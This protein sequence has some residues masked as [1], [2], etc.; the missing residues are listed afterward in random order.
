MYIPITISYYMYLYYYLSFSA[1]TS[2]SCT[3]ASHLP[4]LSIHYKSISILRSTA[5]YT[6]MQRRNHLPRVYPDHRAD[7][8]IAIS[9]VFRKCHSR[10]HNS[11]R[12]AEEDNGS[13]DYADESVLSSW[14]LELVALR[15]S[16]STI[17]FCWFPVCLQTFS[18]HLQ[19]GPR[20]RP[21]LY[22]AHRL[23]ALLWCIRS[24]CQ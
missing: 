11:L 19:P 22:T 18:H 9:N 21:V 12:S 15:F 5:S 13:L 10:L 4:F 20:L 1:S 16:F 14:A 6:T 3:Q 7:P 2:L 24:Y 17:G 23:E 8:D